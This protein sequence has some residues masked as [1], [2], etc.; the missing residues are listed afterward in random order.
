MDLGGNVRFAILLLLFCSASAIARIEIK[1]GQR[2]SVT[3]STSRSSSDGLTLRKERRVA[4]GASAAGP[5]GVLG[6]NLE[7]SFNPRWSIMAGYGTGFTYQ[8]WTFQVK[9]V[10]AGEYLLPYL[11]GGIARWYTTT[12]GKEPISKETQPGYLEKFLSNTEKERGEFSQVLIYPAF[13]LQFIQLSGDYAGLSVFAEL[14]MLLDVG[15]FEAAP[16]GTVGMLY[17]F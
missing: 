14:V 8:S 11:A 15:D 12:P 2:H 17:Y 6:A 5:L 13:G 7:L 10:L 1:D 9:R 3:E 16:T 4:I